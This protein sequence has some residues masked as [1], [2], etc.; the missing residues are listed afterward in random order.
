[1]KTKRAATLATLAIGTFLVPA[2]TASANEW[3]VDAFDEHQRD[4]MCARSR[5]V[6]VPVAGGDQGCA[7][8]QL[9]AADQAP[10]GHVHAE[11]SGR[12]QHR[13]R[14]QRER[15]PRLGRPRPRHARRP[16]NP[17][18]R[19]DPDP[20]SARQVS[21][22]GSSTSTVPATARSRSGV[23]S[24]SR[25]AARRPRRMASTAERSSTRRLPPLARQ[26]AIPRQPHD[27]RRRQRGR[28]LRAGIRP[29]RGPGHLLRQPLRQ[30]GG[31]SPPSRPSARARTSRSSG[32]PSPGTRR[33]RRAAARSPTRVT[34]PAATSIRRCSRRTR[35]STA[36]AQS[37]SEARSTR[38]GL[39]PL[40]S[41]TSP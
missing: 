39:R 40:S 37:D 23:F 16:D 33:T 18:S 10:S 5:P 12:Y 1:M 34:A 2:G 9:G 14:G 27:E 21:M 11:P 22:T 19:A 6:A 15:R 25:V 17:G 38:S 29:Q 28:H 8:R 30:L 32:R 26:R 7:I 13:R 41:V 31:R 4:R 24:P 3:T 20:R 36:T 35:P